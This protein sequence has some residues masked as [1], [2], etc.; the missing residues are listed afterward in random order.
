MSHKLLPTISPTASI[1]DAIA[2]IDAGVSGIALCVTEDRRLIGTVT[3]GDVRRLMLA[4]I[5][6]DTSVQ[7]LLDRKRGT[8]IERPLTV[9]LGTPHDQML[10]LMR[11]HNIRQLP[12]VDAEE[13]VV[14][15]VMLEDLVEEPDVP[16][17]AIIMAG[18]FGKRLRPLTDDVPKPMLQVGDRP[19]IEHV[20]DHLR[21]AGVRQVNISTFYLPEQIVSHFGDG[22]R[23]GV[24]VHYIQEE[25]PRGTAGALG[26]LESLEEPV[27]VT[28]GDILTSINYRSLWDFHRDHEA[29]LTVAVRK[30]EIKVPYGVVNHT[31]TSITG[32]TEK[33]TI[34]FFVNAGIYL[35][36]PE[37][38]KLIPS[39]LPDG[40]QFHMTDLI[41]LLLEQRRKVISFPVHEYWVDI[42]QMEDYQRA[43]DD[44]LQGRVAGR[45]AA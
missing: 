20:V 35:I 30:Y 21:D 37:A 44:V 22:H 26:L 7:V 11:Q 23:F 38:L 24:D 45:R 36:E 39:H 43:Q 42:G 25:C 1:R 28:N 10:Q 29:A 9:A 19:L 2:V 27:L 40:A 32:L 41:Q 12:M 4:N 6:L 17:R 34:E 15:L 8:S 14:R 5:G 16:I 31:E 3:D 13:R 18:G 33:P